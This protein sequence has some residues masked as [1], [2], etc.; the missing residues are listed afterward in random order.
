M[1][2]P[3]LPIQIDQDAVANL[4][5]Q[6]AELRATVEILNADRR[7][8]EAE[9]LAAVKP[10]LDALAAEYV[11]LVQVANERAEGLESAIKAAVVNA[12]HT[13]RGERYMAVYAKGHTSWDT[14][15]L[16]GLAL[17]HPEI[18]ACATVGKPIV[19]L[20]DVK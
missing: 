10:E 9:I 16:Q 15:K 18:S 8:K 5:D 17:A 20:R 7:A 19:S 3:D 4:L 12:G 2:E 11:P 1:T 13:I 6:L 14:K